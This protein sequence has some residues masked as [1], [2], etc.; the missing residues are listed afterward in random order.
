MIWRVWRWL[1]RNERERERGSKSE[2]EKDSRRDDRE[3]D[4]GRDRR[5][6]RDRDRRD[7]RDRHRDRDRR[8]QRDSDHKSGGDS[9]K[10]GQ[11]SGNGLDAKRE[12]EEED[13]E[14]LNIDFDE[15]E[16]CNLSLPCWDLFFWVSG[17]WFGLY[18]RFGW[19]D[20]PRFSKGPMVSGL[21]LEG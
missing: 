13:D 7:D 15:D 6:D 5:D 2:R 19:R 9:G 8:D 11:S 1:F 4:R 12:E 16:V 20:S 18:G 21:G 17:L 3:R 10:G 14:P